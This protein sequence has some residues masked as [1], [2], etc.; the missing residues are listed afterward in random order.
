M[1]EVD[2][3]KKYKK[4]LAEEFKYKENSAHQHSGPKNSSTTKIEHIKISLQIE[5][6]F[7]EEFEFGYCLSPFDKILPY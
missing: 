2:I 7:I 4:S 6:G 3:K 5:H 1:I